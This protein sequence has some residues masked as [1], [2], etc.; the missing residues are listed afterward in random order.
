MVT[1]FLMIDYVLSSDPLV[2]AHVIPTMERA[3]RGTSIFFYITRKIFW[4]IFCNNIK[5]KAYRKGY[6]YLFL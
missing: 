1:Y 4:I 3:Q 6:L 2:L 5:F